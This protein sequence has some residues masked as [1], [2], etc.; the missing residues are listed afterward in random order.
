MDS[1]EAGLAART[2]APFRPR[3]RSAQVGCPWP[4]KERES[5]PDDRPSPEVDRPAPGHD[6]LHRDRQRASARLRPRLSRRRHALA[7]GHAPAL[8]PLPLHRSRPAP[9]L[10]P[11]RDEARCRPLP[12]RRRPHRRR[13]PGRARARGRH[14]D[15]QR[16][17]RRDLP[18]RRDQPS[19]APRPARAD[20]LRHLQGLPAARLP[21]PPG[22]GAHSRRDDRADADDAPAGDAPGADRLR[23]ADEEADPRR[24]ARPLGRPRDGGQSRAARRTKPFAGSRIA[25]RWRPPRSSHRSTAPP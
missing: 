15:R 20:P 1:T 11:D 25:T 23:L 24:A 8:G 5:A 16:H 6:Q 19:G 18:A 3:R 22:R 4:W 21:L 7:R 10:A 17:R 2:S 9:G 14:P 13:L 12:S